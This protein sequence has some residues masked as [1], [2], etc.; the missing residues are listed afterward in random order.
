MIGGDQVVESFINLLVTATRDNERILLIDTLGSLKNQISADE[1]PQNIYYNQD[2]VAEAIEN[3]VR[4]LI[5]EKSP[6]NRG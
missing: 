4:R 3:N 2:A 6:I 1:L 5:I